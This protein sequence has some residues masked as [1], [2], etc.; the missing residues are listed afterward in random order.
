MPTLAV[1]FFGITRDLERT[2]PSIER[3]ILNPARSLA[4]VKVY[5][6]LYAIE[7]IDNPRSKEAASVDPDDGKLLP[8]DV[9]VF[10]KPDS[11]EIRRN[12]S[13]ISKMG[14]AWGD[15]FRSLNNL[16]HQLHSLSRVT[17]MA[18]KD[19]ADT[20]VFC[21]PDL[22]Y[23]DNLEKP[24]TRAIKSR[25]AMVQLPYWQPFGGLNDRFSVCSGQSAASA[26][27]NRVNLVEKFCFNEKSPLHAEQL[28]AF[29][30]AQHSVPVST[31]H[32]RATRARVGGHDV[33]EDF[34]FPIRYELKRRYPHLSAI[35]KQGRKL[36]SNLK[37]TS[38]NSS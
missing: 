12:L 13:A 22:I 11:E 6:H 36:L 2:F 35:V 5:S 20:Y 10:E 31:F 21:R 4:E 23:H 15:N 27:G 33:Q 28:L 3:N 16:I 8:S 7:R 1:C 19:H 32:H 18:L 24:L 25:K 17:Q 30:L 26:Y 34:S 37:G 14:D 29:S 38:I 9:S